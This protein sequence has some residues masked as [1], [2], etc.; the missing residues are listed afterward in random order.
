M[1]TLCNQITGWK[2]F[3]ETAL[4]ID[5]PLTSAVAAV[6]GAGGA[7]WTEFATLAIGDVAEMRA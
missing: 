2:S 3:P 7:L 1:R 6:V 4:A 5:Y